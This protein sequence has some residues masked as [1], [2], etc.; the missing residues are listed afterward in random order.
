MPF[1]WLPAR[2]RVESL[3]LSSRPVVRCPPADSFAQQ[4]AGADGVPAS[5]GRGPGP[6]RGSARRGRGGEGAAARDDER[7]GDDGRGAEDAAALRYRCV[8]V[9]QILHNSCHVTTSLSMLRRFD[10]L[11][12]VSWLAD[13]RAGESRG[14]R[15]LPNTRCHARCAPLAAADLL[16]VVCHHSWWFKLMSGNH[17]GE[18][19][20]SRWLLTLLAFLAETFRG[21]GR[22]RNRLGRG[23]TTTHAHRAHAAPR[24]PRPS[25]PPG[26]RAAAAG[27]SLAGGGAGV[28]CAVRGAIH[29]ELD[30]GEGAGLSGGGRGRLHLDAVRTNARC[31]RCPNVAEGCVVELQAAG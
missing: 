8:P 25:F 23:P 15:L 5:A 17:L 18:R 11:T 26:L 24:G 12:R 30:D 27:H 13:I 29:A 3:N 19:L 6:R 22:V 20:T 10:V 28:R 4:R 1:V 7:R 2:E 16:V 21:N 9:V 31:L 14:A